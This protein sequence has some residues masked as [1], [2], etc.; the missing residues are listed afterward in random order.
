MAFKLPRS[1]PDMASLGCGGTSAP[2]NP[3]VSKFPPPT[4]W[5]QIAHQPPHIELKSSPMLSINTDQ[6]ML[7]HMGQDN[8][9]L[10]ND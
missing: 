4:T 3:Q 5:L 9:F 7:E 2:S 1:Q 8:T 6:I 10:F